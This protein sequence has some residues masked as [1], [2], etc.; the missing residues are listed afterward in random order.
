MLIRTLSRKS[1]V[2]QAARVSLAL[3]TLFSSGCGLINKVAPGPGPHDTRTSYHDS[4]GLQISY[5][6]VR[7]CANEVTAAARTSVSPLVAEDPSKIPTFD[8]TLADA[9]QMAVRQSPVVRELGGTLVTQ[10][11]FSQ[12]IYDPSLAHANPQIGVE[13]DRKSTRLNSRH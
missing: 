8:L 6:E 13:A 4:V 3:G 7:D 2:N 12:T 1:R 11:G 5:P 10:P 9:V